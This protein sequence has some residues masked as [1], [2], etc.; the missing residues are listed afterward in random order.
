MIAALVL[1]DK[2]CVA[3]FFERWLAIPFLEGRGTV[4]QVNEVLE[5]GLL[6]AEVHERD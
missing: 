3:L 4:L 2:R 5:F 6:A 1:I